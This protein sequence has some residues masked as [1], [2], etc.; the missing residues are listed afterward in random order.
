M[1]HRYI[2]FSTAI[3][4]ILQICLD[5]YSY[6]TSFKDN[7][8]YASHAF[9][10]FS[11][12]NINLPQPIYKFAISGDQT[13]VIVSNNIGGNP[14]F[15]LSL[16]SSTT[17][18]WSAFTKTLTTNI[19]VKGFALYAWGG[20]VFVRL[21]YNGMM[22]IIAG[23]G[24][25]SFNTVSPL[26][27][28]SWSNK[29]NDYTITNKNIGYYKITNNII[30]KTPIN[31]GLRYT[32]I[33]I[34]PNGN[35]IVAA[36]LKWAYGPGYCYYSFLN[37]GGSYDPLKPILPNILTDIPNA[38]AIAVSPNGNIIA[39]NDSTNNYIRYCVW[40]NSTNTYTNEVKIITKIG[41]TNVYKFSYDSSILFIGSNN[42]I[43]YWKKTNNSNF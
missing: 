23:T 22:G 34:T 9:G 6:T 31:Y 1:Y 15:Y 35:V 41:S 17:K 12:I 39:Y 13:K 3:L 10:L 16:F 20:H 37:S 25:D 4:I 29:I 36:T 28:I 43:Y 11:G 27:I 2:Y 5:A 40:N 26:A 21:Q 19:G 30:D 24:S 18:S 33:D 8:S 38:T 42:S 32:N 7:I 14:S